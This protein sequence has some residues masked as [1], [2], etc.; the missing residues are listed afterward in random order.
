MDSKPKIPKELKPSMTIEQQIELLKSRKLNL[1]EDLAYKTLNRLSYYRLV[2]AYSVGYFKDSAKEEYKE[3]FSF[4][5]LLDIYN[6]DQ[7]LRSILLYEIESIET[8]LRTRVAYYIAVNYGPLGHEDPRN[9][10]EV[11]I[12]GEVMKELKTQ[13]ERNLTAPCVK[14]HNEVYGGKMPIWAAIELFSFGM[15]SKLLSAMK[16]IDQNSISKDLTTHTGKTVR[17]A[18]LKSWI[19]CLVE[20]RNICA[21][22]GRL[23]NKPVI[24]TP[25]LY[26][27]YSHITTNK[28]FLVL[29]VIKHLSNLNHQQYKTFVHQVEGL[30][31][32]HANSIDLKKIGFPKDW[33]TLLEK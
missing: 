32:E 6:F 10:S 19:Q 26:E 29:L 13:I 22:Y 31:N 25:K 21:H 3:N 18:Y 30:I 8:H 16:T 27:E 33:K 14:H 20:V 9:F 5:K 7:A 23:Y 1:D 15:L 17:Y 12:H 4:S 2:N 11:K 28:V 24:A